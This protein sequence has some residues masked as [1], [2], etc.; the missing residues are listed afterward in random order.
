MDHQVESDDGVAVVVG[1][2][3][4]RSTRLAGGGR[5]GSEKE[6]ARKLVLDAG[7]RMAR[8]QVLLTHTRQLDTDPRLLFPLAQQVPCLHCTFSVPYACTALIAADDDHTFFLV[9]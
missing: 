2:K 8:D 9:K 3:L 5:E 1:L 7:W 6:V 4:D